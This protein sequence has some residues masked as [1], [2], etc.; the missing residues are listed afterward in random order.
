MDGVK[1]EVRDSGQRERGSTLTSSWSASDR[2][3]R[4]SELDDLQMSR[5]LDDHWT[6]RWDEAAKDGFASKPGATME[7][8]RG[9]KL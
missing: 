4:G 5:L 8:G 9:E 2:L 7:E 3:E 6:P 1:E